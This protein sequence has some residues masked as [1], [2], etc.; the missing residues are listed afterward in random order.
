MS[1]LKSDL[2]I[3]RKIGEG[4]FGEVFIGDDPVHG[5]VAVKRLVKDPAVSNAEWH[6]RKNRLVQEAQH[7]KQATHR[8][9]VRVHHLLEDESGDAILLVMDFCSG[10]SLQDVFDSG[11]M[12]LTE[13]RK[14]ATEV[15]HGLQALHAREMLHRDI[16]PGNLLIN[17]KG[18]A[19]LGDFGLV[20]DELILGYGSQAGYWD[21]IAP[22]IHAGGGT[23]VKTDIWALGVTIYRLLHGASWCSESP[24]PVDLVPN[25]G[26][27]GKLR[28]LPHVPK[29]WRRVVR[30]MLRDDPAR[31]YQT[32]TEVFAALSELPTQPNWECTVSAPEVRWE[33]LKRSRR[34]VVVWQ[35]HSARRHE[36]YAWSEPVATG[37]HRSLGG[38]KGIIGRTATERELQDFFEGQS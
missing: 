36:W 18:V 23:S 2:K 17:N 19:Q 38:S 22:E 33:R 37:R 27:A 30:A 12:T 31:R 20:T 9:V 7:L 11:T 21:H 6:G 4:H 24:A 34:I 26:F 28:W 35:R 10:G 5:V 16:K 32:A 1:S 8:N 25:G 13:L 29:K 14:I 3:G 15:T